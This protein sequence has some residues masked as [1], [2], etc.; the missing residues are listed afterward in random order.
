MFDHITTRLPLSF[1][2][3][4]ESLQDS[5]ALLESCNILLRCCLD[6]ALVITQLGV[7][8]LSVWGCRHGSAEDRLDDE[9]VVRLE[10]V[11]ISVTE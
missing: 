6:L 1:L 3:V 8:V 5:D 4:L 10:G 2:A 9:G 11:A 7:E